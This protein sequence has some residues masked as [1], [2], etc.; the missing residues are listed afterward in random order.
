MRQGAT[1]EEAEKKQDMYTEFADSV[2]NPGTKHTLSFD[3]ISQIPNPTQDMYELNVCCYIALRR[4]C[5]DAAQKLQEEDV[6]RAKC[7]R[8]AEVRQVQMYR[9]LGILARDGIS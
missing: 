7:Q 8:S 2:T 9:Q 4:Y 1:S 3:K 6:Q 5:T